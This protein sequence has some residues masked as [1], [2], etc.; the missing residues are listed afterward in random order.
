MRKLLMIIFA[1]CVLGVQAQKITRPETIRTTEL[2]NQKMQV[3]DSTFVLVLKSGVQPITIVLGKKEK[4]LQ[5]LRFLYEADVRK[6]DIIELGNEAGDAAKFNGLKQY[7]FFSPGRQFT[8]QMAKRYLKG[9]IEAVEN[10][11]TS[12]K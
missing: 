12:L 5:I 9:Y 8:C 7:E 2:G 6:G 11:G 1:C 10:Y 3:V 4:A